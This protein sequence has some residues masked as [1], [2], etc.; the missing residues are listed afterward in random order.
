M[1]FD[2][3]AIDE[4][5]VEFYAEGHG[6]SGDLFRRGFAG[7]VVNTLIHARRLGLNVALISRIG[8][9][10]FAPLMRNAWQDEG[11][12]LSHAP[13]VPGCNGIY[14]ILTDAAGEREF[15]YR[16]VGSAASELGSADLDVAFQQSA[17]IVRLSG[18]TQAISDTAAALT[19]AASRLPVLTT[20]DPN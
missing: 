3:I 16:R 11:V 12:D 13:V 1:S 2:L 8:D 20:Y 17:A 14:F 19:R 7:E 5:M 10:A 15:I 4:G 6:F 18:I 9:D